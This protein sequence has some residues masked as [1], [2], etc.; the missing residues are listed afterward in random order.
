MII[1]IIRFDEEQ[2]YWMFDDVRKYSLSNRLSKNT[3]LP[4]PDCDAVFFDAE[5]E[6]SCKPAEGCSECKDYHRI[7]CRLGDGSE[8]TIAF[9]TIAY[10][11]NDSGKTIEKIVANYG[12]Y[13][14]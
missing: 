1:K 14:N 4:L 7:I 3:E 6:C 8:Y 10:V 2:N 12:K 5:V 9:D 13:K 11:L